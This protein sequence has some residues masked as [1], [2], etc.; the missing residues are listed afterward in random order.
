[1]N[2]GVVASICLAVGLG[3]VTAVNKHLLSTNL[4]PLT[5]SKH[6]AHSLL[7]Q[8]KMVNVK[9]GVKAKPTLRTVIL[10]NYKM[11][12]YQKLKTLLLNTLFIQSL[13]TTGTTQE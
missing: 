6:W 1:M 3:I 10:N 2:S 5:L 7:P 8:M 4:D 11:D 12:F 9:Y 13:F